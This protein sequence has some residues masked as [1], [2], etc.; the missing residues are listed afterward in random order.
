[1]PYGEIISTPNLKEQLPYG[2]ATLL[3]E[4]SDHV[5]LLADYS[6]TNVKRLRLERNRTSKE[7]ERK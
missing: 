2:K 7:Q 3:R 4:T 5:W 6:V 1:M